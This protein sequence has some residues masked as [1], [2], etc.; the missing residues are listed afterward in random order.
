VIENQF[1]GEILYR[2]IAGALARRIVNYAHEGLQV[3]QGDDAGFIKFGSRVDLFFPIGTKI[4]VK[5]QQ[6]AIGN[7]TIIASLS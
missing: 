2:Q 5:L 6:K 7:K 4:E 1:F 3:S